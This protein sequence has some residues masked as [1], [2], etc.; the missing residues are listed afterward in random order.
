MFWAFT[1]AFLP[2]AAPFRD[3]LCP[4]R[5]PS[6]QQWPATAA[7]ASL[8]A[9]KVCALG[10]GG[11][12]GLHFQPRLVLGRAYKSSESL[13]LSCRSRS[14]PHAAVPWSLLPRAELNPTFHGL[15]ELE[16]R[17]RKPLERFRISASVVKPRRVRWTGR[18]LQLRPWFKKV[19]ENGI[20]S[21]YLLPDP[22]SGMSCV[23]NEVTSSAT[24][25][26]LASG[27]V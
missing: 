17:R 14:P 6:R 1:L 13:S 3:F 12:W 19:V 15:S 9:P 26:I 2:C 18:S 22:A 20:R 25:L 21:T 7:F 10:E 8:E 5:R 11:L 24:V 16:I 23:T 27:A 4:F